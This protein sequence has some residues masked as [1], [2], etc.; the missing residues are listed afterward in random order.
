MFVCIIFLISGC[1][2]KDQLVQGLESGCKDQ[3]VQEQEKAQ[4]IGQIS[5]PANSL[6]LSDANLNE[7][8]VMSF[9]IRHNDANDPQSLDER[10]EIILQVII[11]NDPAIVGL[12]EF[13]NDWFEAWLPPKMESLG[14]DVYNP[15]DFSSPKAI[16]YKSD[17]FT[18]KD[19]GNFTVILSEQRSGTWVILE[20]VITNKQYFVSNSHWTTY[21]SSER[22][23]TAD[24]ILDV[25]DE[26]SQGL[27]LIIFGDFNA[28][29][30]TPEITTI[31]DANGF[32]LVSTHSETGDTFHGWHAE[33]KS[34]LDWI[35][36]SRDLGYLSTAVITTTYDGYWPSDHWPITATIVPAIFSDVTYDTHDVS[37]EST[38]RYYFVD[39]TG[40]RK[41][42]KIYLDSTHDSS[43]I[44]VYESNGDGTFSFLD[45]NTNGASQSSI[46]FYYF[47]DVTGDG[48]ADM[49]SWDRSYDSGQTRVYSSNGDGTFTSLDSNTNA[50][51]TDSST[52]FYFADVTGDGMADMI[53]WN[54]KH[55]SGHTQIYESNGDGTFSFLDSNTNGG[56][57]SNNT[58][59][60]FADV[61]GDGAADKIYWNPGDYMGKLKIYLSNSDGS[62]DGPVYSLRGN[63]DTSITQYYFAD[64]NGDGKS[65]QIYWN[66]LESLGGHSQGTLKNYFSIF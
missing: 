59:F 44:R 22:V 40:D 29:P 24:K 30:G 37:S 48:K 57:Q 61:T 50:A 28:Q 19:E 14:Y 53:S 4:P 34:K 32:D 9:N 55:D 42:D 20:D 41:A 16:F 35:F 12:Q 27:P 43:H 21:L 63:S 13:S 2:D 65:D 8:K 17:R 3:L 46:S 7:F 31:K 15:T 47:A 10:K 45:S 52:R 64:I 58:T 33:G 11:E 54:P 56:S 36:S 5:S 51:S 38:T 25:I 26:H 66:R 6:G 23:F 18:R 39:V 49:I 62:F 1:K 60:Y